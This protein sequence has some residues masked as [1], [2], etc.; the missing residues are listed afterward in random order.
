MT[1][2]G[3]A[4]P[5]LVMV[6]PTWIGGLGVMRS[7]GRLGIR[8]YGL[9]HRGLSIPNA[10]RYCAGV[11]QAADNG[12]PIGSADQIVKA[13]VRAGRKLDGRVIL[14]PGTD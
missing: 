8:V 13:L 12:R 1:R 2:S 10:S 5:V 14:I 6:P 3:S 9:A 11:V 4:V 7:L